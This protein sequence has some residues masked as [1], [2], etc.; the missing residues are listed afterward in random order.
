ML[1]PD[2]SSSSRHAAAISVTARLKTSRPFGMRTVWSFASTVSA[3]GGVRVPPAGIHRI[4][5]APPSAPSTAPFEPGHL[6]GPH[7]R[8][9]GAVAEEH[10]CAAVGEVDDAAED[11]GPDQ[12]DRVG[13][14][15]ADERAWMPTTRRRTPST[16][17]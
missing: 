16:Q 13:H 10:A 15:G 8:G 5:A 4:S 6:A 1:S 3:E 12:Q 2:F 14:A 11:L 7:D 17:R 9:A